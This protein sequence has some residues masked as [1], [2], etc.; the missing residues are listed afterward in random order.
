[1]SQDLKSQQHLVQALVKQKK[2]IEDNQRWL[3]EIKKY[4][5]NDND[6]Q[7]MKFCLSYTLQSL[8]AGEDFNRFKWRD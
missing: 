3:N 8:R 1:M 2:N 6:I 5:K 7:V 4:I